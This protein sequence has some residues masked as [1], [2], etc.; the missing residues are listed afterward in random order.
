MTKFALQKRQYILLAV[1]LVLLLAVAYRYG[2]GLSFFDTG[3]DDIPVKKERLTRYLELREKKIRLEKEA[4]LLDRELA[5]TEGM[6]LQGNTPALAAVDL[7]NRL[8][9]LTRASDVEL[10]TLQVIRPP[11]QKKDEEG[12]YQEIPVKINLKL[13]IRQLKEILYSIADSQTF[14]RVT[15]MTV[16]TDSRK[17]WLLNTDMTVTGLRVRAAEEKH[18]S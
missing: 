3:P 5:E 17:E 8:K 7:Q 18:A 10:H 12:Y 9:D 11:R 16:K 13:T 14:L 6:F 2:P 4:G 1:A 15:D